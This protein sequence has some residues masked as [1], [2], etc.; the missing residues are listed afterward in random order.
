MPYSTSVCPDSLLRPDHIACRKM[1]VKGSPLRKKSE[2]W[3]RPS[4][5]RCRSEQG[6]V[7]SLR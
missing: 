2:G 6:D 4:P 7:H 5:Q 3:D 1:T